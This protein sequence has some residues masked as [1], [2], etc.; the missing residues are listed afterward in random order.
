MRYR[1]ERRSSGVLA[2]AL[3]VGACAQVRF[4]TEEVRVLELDGMRFSV[5]QGYREVQN[6]DGTWEPGPRRRHVV[7]GG[8]RYLCAEGVSDEECLR[9][10]LRLFRLTME[11]DDY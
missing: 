7:I 3:L 5:E 4:V 2:L 11:G 9:V 8:R 10:N 1:Q 6:D